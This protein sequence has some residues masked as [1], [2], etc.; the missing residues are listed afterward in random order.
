MKAVWLTEICARS[1]APEQRKQGTL[2]LIS[3]IGPEAAICEWRAC[4]PASRAPVRRFKRVN[5]CSVYAMIPPASETRRPRLRKPIENGG[6]HPQSHFACPRESPRH[7]VPLLRLELHRAVFGRY[8]LRLES[9]RLCRSR[10]GI[11]GVAVS[12]TELIKNVR[13]TSWLAPDPPRMA[14]L[15]FLIG[16]VRPAR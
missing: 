9:S 14:R 5:L 3:A 4:P 7:R 6:S 13:T 15:D 16:R 11:G 10:A 8:R 1:L 2:G 12:P